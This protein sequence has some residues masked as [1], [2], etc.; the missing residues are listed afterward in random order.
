MPY[1]FRQSLFFRAGLIM[2]GIVILAL[3]SM[4]S[5]IIIAETAR[6]DA[7]A[8][9]Q[10][11]SI[12]MQAYRLYATL[13]EAP[14]ASDLVAQRVARLDDDLGGAAIVS[15]IP[16]ESQHPLTL[17]YH[18]VVR[19]WQEILRPAML[20]A[21]GRDGQAL[22]QQ[23]VRFVDEVDTFVN[24]L[25]ERAESRIEML[26]LVQGIALFL[27]LVLAFV[28]MYKLL[29]DVLPP[30][31]D[32]FNVVNQARHGNFDQRTHY[33]NDD[34]LGLISRTINQMN[35]SLSQMYAQLEQRV[36]LKTTELQRSNE[37][38][39]LLYQ[40]ARRLSGFS[41]TR[42]RY[43]D[44]LER[45]ERITGV[46]SITLHLGHDPAPV[47][48]DTR[49]IAISESG[50][51]YGVLLL[52]YPPEHAPQRWQQELIDTVAGLIASALSLA[53]S[54]EEQRRLAL[55]DERATIARE[56]H[57]SLAQALSY[58]K[59]QVVRLQT[60]IRRRGARADQEAVIDE[61]REG[62][63]SAYRQL[64]ELLN[65]FRLQINTAGLE[66]ALADTTQEFSRRGGLAI[67]L[68]YDLEHGSLTPNEEVHVLHIVREALANVVHH[69]E[70]RRC[71]VR[72]S[73]DTGGSVSIS[74][75]DDGMGLPERWERPN[76]YG[77]I[78]MR[79]RAAGLG[80]RLTL[81]RHP[82]GG[83]IVTLHFMPRLTNENESSTLT[84]GGQ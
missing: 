35:E 73:S 42:E 57:D 22:A 41:P 30:L 64:R 47:T 79:E 66:M 45:L 26:R 15:L 23:I 83:T 33:R 7:A 2:A 76:H 4:L 13:G 62:L 31:R 59:I 43:R 18:E 58:L 3:T 10:A 61:L 40:A 11:G 38:L 49:S 82:D 9:N 69:A 75:R 17:R 36:A 56:L 24:Q 1:S 54:N 67:R 6:G 68:E 80:G 37:A 21:D 63:G 12:R 60:L 14:P 77:T 84:G 8:I 25:Q 53:Q 55:L 46:D 29:T 70:A 44:V 50:R 32:L 27:T 28:A 72:L 16:N 34:E 52:R 65:T 81:Q 39:S 51:H 71:D 74:V 20:E 78:I 5:S 48:A 19:Q